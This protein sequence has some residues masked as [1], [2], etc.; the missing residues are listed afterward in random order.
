M[1]TSTAHGLTIGRVVY[2]DQTMVR[3]MPD[4]ASDRAIEFPLTADGSEFEPALGVSEVEV[5]EETASDYYVDFLGAKPGELLEFFTLDG[6][7]AAPVGTVAEVIKSATKDNIRLEDGRVL[8]FRGRGPE[9]PIAVIRVRTA[10]NV[11]AAA[12]AAGEAAS[13]QRA[14][15]RSRG[16]SAFRRA[17]FSRFSPARGS[18]PGPVGRPQTEAAHKSA[19]HPVHRARSGPR[20]GAEKLRASPQ[21]RR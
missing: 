19:P 6:N 2:R 7:E 4:E 11:A 17:Q 8:K 1:L 21:H 9:P 14:A 15:L 5:I 12:G 10:A 16:D 20:R 13:A 3:I 18:L